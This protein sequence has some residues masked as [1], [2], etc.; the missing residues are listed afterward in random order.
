M[1]IFKKAIFVLGIVS[2]I[3]LMAFKG[4]FLSKYLAGKAMD[5]YVE[6]N[7]SGMDLERK[8][9]FYD[10]K[11]GSRYVGQYHSRTSQD[12]FFSIDTDMLGRIKYDSYKDRVDNGWNTIMRIDKN[13][14]E[15]VERIVRENMDYEIDIVSGSLLLD[16]YESI[17]SIEGIELD[18]DYDLNNI[19]LE[20]ELY[21]SIVD[22]DLTWEN[23]AEKTLEIDRLMREK[24]IDFKV[25]SVNLLEIKDGEKVDSLCIYDFPKEKLDSKD[26]ASTME[27][28]F[29]EW[30]KD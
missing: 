19:P 5:S 24:D 17:E 4:N 12:R 6:E 15:D 1:S 14:D 13:F 11:R 26:L 30:N 28:F 29:D 3:I 10:S 21:I 23:L 20:K 9:L 27:K 22:D 2:I 8:D 16:D 25:Y 18:M 7:Y